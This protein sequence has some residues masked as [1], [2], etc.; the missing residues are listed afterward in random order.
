MVH[1]TQQQV[2]QGTT[3]KV[4]RRYQTSHSLASKKKDSARCLTTSPLPGAATLLW[5]ASSWMRHALSSLLLCSMTMSWRS[6][7]GRI[8]PGCFRYAEYNRLPLLLLPRFYST[9]LSRSAACPS[10]PSTSPTSPTPS[11]GWAS[12]ATTG[13]VAAVGYEPTIRKDYTV[14]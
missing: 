7:A 9:P 11:P 1:T 2:K 4:W 13:V 12:G 10:A 5:E 6:T 14:K 8:D 3:Q